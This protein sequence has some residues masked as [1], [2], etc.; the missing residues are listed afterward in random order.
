MITEEKDEHYSYEYAEGIL[1]IR[2][3]NNIIELRPDEVERLLIILR[4]VPCKG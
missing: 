4:W 1:K 2:S 3:P